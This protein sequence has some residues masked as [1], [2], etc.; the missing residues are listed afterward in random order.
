MPIEVARQHLR[1]DHTYDDNLIG[2]YLSA[3]R[4]WIESYLGRN[5]AVQQFLWVSAKAPFVG[6]APFVALPYPIQV[7]PLWYPWP[8]AINQPTDLPRTPL[9]SVDAVGYGA[10]GQPET[11]LPASSY[12]VD[13]ELGRLRLA[14]GAVPGGH[15]HLSVRFTAGF[16]DPRAIPSSIIAGVLMLLTHLYENRGDAPAEPPAPIVRLLAMHRRLTFGG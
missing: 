2:L 12:Q 8:D 13:A 6:A 7:N 4:E 11:E 5:L 14:P 1:V 10:W 3:A 9:V 15:D 16:T